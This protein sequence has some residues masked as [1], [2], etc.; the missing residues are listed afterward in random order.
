MNKIEKLKQQI[1]KIESKKV[2]DRTE[3]EHL[4]LIKFKYVRSVRNYL[5]SMGKFKYV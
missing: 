4:F 3:K 2:E 1:E 5:L